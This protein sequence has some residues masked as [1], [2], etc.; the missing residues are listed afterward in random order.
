MVKIFLSMKHTLLFL[1]VSIQLVA[2]NNL[3]THQV[4]VLNDGYQ[5]Y[6]TEEIIVPVTLGTYDPV[7]ET[8]TIV[9]TIDGARF[10][11]DILIEGQFVYVAADKDLLK[12]DK[13]TYQLIS[14]QQVIGIRNIAIWND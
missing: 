6:V 4:F 13:D 11:S 9:D 10:A 3:Y 5:D 7:N 1:F 12:Y 14:S 2:Q 8:Y